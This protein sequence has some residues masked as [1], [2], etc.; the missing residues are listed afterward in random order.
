MQALP[1][2]CTTRGAFMESMASQ[3]DG[4]ASLSTGYPPIVTHAE[5]TLSLS[6]TGSLVQSPMAL[7]SLS[8]ES[9]G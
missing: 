6:G 8:R 2:Y 5:N 3:K 1:M 4:L 9:C 7:A